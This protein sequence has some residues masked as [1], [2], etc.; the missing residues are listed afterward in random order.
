MHR[1]ACSPCT[2]NEAGHEC[3]KDVDVPCNDKRPFVPKSSVSDACDCSRIHR[4][5]VKKLRIF[6]VRIFLKT[7]LRRSRTKAGYGHTRSLEFPTERDGE[8]HDVRFACK[9]HSHER[10]GLKC[11]GRCDIENGSR[12]TLHHPRKKHFCEI[13]QCSDIHLE[14]IFFLIIWRFMEE[15]ERAEAG[16]IHERMNTYVLPL[17]FLNEVHR[18][19]GQGEI[20]GNDLRRDAM[21]RFQFRC[22]GL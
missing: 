4:F 16:V 15:S 14:Q 21:C 12:L 22:E 18:S 2:G 9:V 1:N 19:V 17:Q 3:S 20:Y 5:S 6:H 10:T 11:S 8:M 7:G 13:G